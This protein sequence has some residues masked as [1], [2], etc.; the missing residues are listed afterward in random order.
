MV[1]IKKPATCNNVAYTYVAPNDFTYVLPNHDTIVL[2]GTAEQ[3]QFELVVDHAV[4]KRVLGN[5]LAFLPELKQ[6]LHVLKAWTGRRPTRSP[7]RMEIEEGMGGGGGG[8]RLP[9]VLHLYGHGGCGVTIG[10]GSAHDAV[11]NVIK[12]FLEQR[13]RQT[14]GHGSRRSKI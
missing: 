6:D 5:A 2:G 1:R 7:L 3:N 8:A 13:R 4:T 10:I 11:V 9:P 12:P 14:K